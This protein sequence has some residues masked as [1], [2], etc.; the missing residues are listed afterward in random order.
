L[1]NFIDF[2]KFG[3]FNNILPIDKMTYVESCVK[4]SDGL[5]TI[6]DIL[7]EVDRIG[8]YDP[9]QSFAKI[10]YAF[11][12][13]FSL[14]LYAYSWMGHMIRTV[15]Y[16]FED[17][18]DVFDITLMYGHTGTAKSMIRL[19]RFSKYINVFSFVT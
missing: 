12:H 16:N 17:K 9:V 14:L 18:N 6:E 8:S 3:G 11:T 13:I 1:D 15:L 19:V 2:I 5:E 4:R 7:G 10:G